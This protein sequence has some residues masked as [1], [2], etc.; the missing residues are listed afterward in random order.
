MFEVISV[1]VRL[2]RTLVVE[3]GW[4]RNSV[5]RA[6]VTGGR[7]LMRE[8]TQEIPDG[9]IKGLGQEVLSWSKGRT[10]D[11]ENSEVQRRSVV[12]MEGFG[13][14]RKWWRFEDDRYRVFVM[15]G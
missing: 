15:G 4:G 2:L 3:L 12:V 10:I 6:Q 1:T 5:C 14:G 7:Q 13:L 9:C 11:K 8:P